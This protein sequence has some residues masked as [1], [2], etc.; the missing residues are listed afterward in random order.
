MKV[1]RMGDR[2]SEKNIKSWSC[3]KKLFY[4]ARKQNA[5]EINDF[6]VLFS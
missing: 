4:F 2:E 5:Q 1:I 3:E 6:F